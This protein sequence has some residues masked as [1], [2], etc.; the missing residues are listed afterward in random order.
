MNDLTDNAEETLEALLTGGPAAAANRARIAVGHGERTLPACPTRVLVDCRGCGHQ[1]ILSGEPGETCVFCGKLVKY[2]PRNIPVQEQKEEKVMVIE[3]KFGSIVG[4][5]P[6][7]PAR[8]A[9]PAGYTL[10]ARMMASSRY[11]EDNRAAIIKEWEQQGRPV[12]LKRWGIAQSTLNGLLARWGLK[13]KRQKK[14]ATDSSG[15]QPEKK[16]KPATPLPAKVAEGDTGQPAGTQKKLMPGLVV[17]TTWRILGM[18]VFE[19][20][21]RKSAE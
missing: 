7:V 2:M 18:P 6:P 14:G 13:A 1:I 4:D 3:E 9:V 16:F 19:R 12:Q 11:Y 20:R 21:V 8:P 17:V 5:L 15:S 10:R